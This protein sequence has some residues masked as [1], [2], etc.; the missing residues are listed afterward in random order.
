VSSAWVLIVDGAGSG[1]FNMKTDESLLARQQRA[2][3]RPSVRIYRWSSPT[4]TH[5]RFQEARSIR[6]WNIAPRHIPLVRR[7]TAG[8]AVFHDT[9][10][11]FS[12][13]WKRGEL[14]PKDTRKI[15]RS[16][17]GAAR[18]ALADQGVKTSF[19]R[20]PPGRRDGSAARPVN[21]C[22]SEPVKDDL[23]WNGRKVLGGAL[24]FTRWGG[25]Y[26]GNLTGIQ[27]LVY[28]D[29][30]DALAGALVKKI[31]GRKPVVRR[32]GGPVK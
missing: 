7:P 2:D 29:F 21:L 19:H 17:H 4:I 3:A 8:G 5:G 1:A 22:F 20:R 15:Y 25:L 11:S 6:S 13:A 12:I 23:M 18:A 28:K 26:Q 30:V 27:G 16:I 10:L 32:S 14:F 31:F 24:R 9:D